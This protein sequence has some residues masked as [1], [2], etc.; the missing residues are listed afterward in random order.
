MLKRILLGLTFIAAFTT[1]GIGIPDS[2]EAWR[3]WGVRPYA[4]YY[5]GPPRSYYYNSYVPYR[6]YYGPRFYR[7]YYGRYYYGGPGYYYG[8][9]SGMSVSVGF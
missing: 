1:V 5:Y 7:P 2:A 9:R 3:R 6:A 8:P 4:S